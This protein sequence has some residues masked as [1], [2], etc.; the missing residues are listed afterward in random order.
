MDIQKHVG[1]F[2]RSVNYWQVFILKS[3]ETVL[4]KT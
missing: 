2:V 1:K 3:T 4:P